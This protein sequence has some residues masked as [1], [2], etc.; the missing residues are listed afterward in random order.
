M[1]FSPW[2]IL[3]V[4]LAMVLLFGRGKVAATMGEFGEGLKIFRRTMRGESEELAA[5]QEDE[6]HTG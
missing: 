1:E 3:I 4:A 5:T 6:T 2:H